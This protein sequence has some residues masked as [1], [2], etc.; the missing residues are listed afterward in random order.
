M[1]AVHDPEM[2]RDK[3]DG[4]R[5]GADVVCDNNP[6][7]CHCGFQ[8]ALVIDAAQAW[9][10]RGERDGVYPV[11]CEIFGKPARIVLVQQEPYLDRLR[12]CRAPADVPRPPAPRPG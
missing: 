11:G 7:F 2:I 10:V 9:P 5:K 3:Y 6:A 1:V 4:R 8:H 12:H